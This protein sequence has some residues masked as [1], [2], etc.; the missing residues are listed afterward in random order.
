M[1]RFT[2]MSYLVH[3]FTSNYGR[4]GFNQF[5]DHSEVIQAWRKTRGNFQLL[6]G[7]PREM[8]WKLSTVGS[9]AVSKKLF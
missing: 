4:K 6:E 1:I 3:I 2:G 7:K 9:L 8:T 5:I